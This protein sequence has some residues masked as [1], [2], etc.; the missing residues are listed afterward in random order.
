QREDEPAAEPRR[1]VV[2]REKAPAEDVE[3]DIPGIE[4]PARRSSRPSR[5]ADPEPEPASVRPSRRSAP[6]PEQ[7]SEPEPASVRPS[8]RSAPVQEAPTG[9]C[10]VGG[11]FGEDCNS[12]KECDDCKLWNECQD[13]KD[14]I[15]AQRRNAKRK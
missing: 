1:R 9:K 6:P 3:D 4:V 15:D 2:S 7:D 10:P 8:R 14:K 13:E 12:L 11:V 5:Q